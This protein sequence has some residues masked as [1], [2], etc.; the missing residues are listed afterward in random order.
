MNVTWVPE[1]NYAVYTLRLCMAEKYYAQFIVIVLSKV[2]G[3]LID[4]HCINLYLNLH[5]SIE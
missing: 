4:T 2:S 1:I 3:C 5:D